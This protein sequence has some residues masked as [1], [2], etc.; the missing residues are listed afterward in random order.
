[1]SKRQPWVTIVHPGTQHAQ[2]LA[3]QLY[4]HRL[5]NKLV[6]GLL[7]DGN[8][9]A[10]HLISKLAQIVGLQRQYENRLL[11]GIPVSCVLTRATI[12][13]GA[14][15]L[16]RMGFRSVFVYRQRNELFQSTVPSSLIKESDVVIGFDT[17]ARRISKRT[18]DLG[19]LFVLDQSIGHPRSL[20]ATLN[21]LDER[22][23]EWSELRE[24]KSDREIELE[25]EEH[26][27][28]DLIVAPS[29][30]VAR[31]LVENGVAPEKIRVN[32]FG[33]D[34]MHFTP[35]GK[36]ERT[37]QTTF[38]FLGS[39]TSRK[40]VPILLEAW[41]RLKT[42]KARLI[43]AG[44]GRIPDGV[45]RE[46]PTGVSVL[47][48][49]KRSALPALFSKANVFV[50][51]SLF[52][53][54]ALVQVEAAACGLPIIGTTASGAEDIVESERTGLIVPAGDV[55]ALARAI[56]RLIRNPQEVDAM[57]QAARE[58]A[59]QWDWSGYGD[60]WAELVSELVSRPAKI[61]PTA[62]I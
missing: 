36:A 62:Q 7:I 39:F 13:L 50:F 38:L 26:Q 21:N 43:L 47:G 41:R 33:T 5:L 35:I 54:L 42:T 30:F 29:H 9:Y 20:R 59:R 40:G 34:T 48:P 45:S 3:Y 12:E 51:P 52:E 27:T 17:S 61:T 2:R 14:L 10:G 4:R 57:H 25:E 11:N 1:M 46:L 28:A 55:D 58:R 49:I 24:R 6:T 32:P 18:K 31:T 37:K 53:G 16:L 23:P 56:D 15:A 8:S 60:R 44:T 22:Y 19:K